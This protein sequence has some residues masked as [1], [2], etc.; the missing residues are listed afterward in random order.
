MTTTFEE[1]HLAL[2]ANMAL[3]APLPADVVVEPTALGGVPAEWVVVP[4]SG[5]GVVLFFHGGGYVIGSP[6]T[7][8][9]L[10]ARIARA[11]GARAVSVDYRLAPAHPFPAALD[12]AMAAYAA[13]VEQCPS[14]RVA[15]AGDS[16]GAGLALATLVRARDEGLPLPAAV[17]LLSPWVD[18]S[19]SAAPAPVEDLPREQLLGFAEAYLAGADPET[20]L[21]SPLF[22]DLAGLPPCLVHVGAAE[23]LLP[24]AE[25]LAERLAAAGV[26]V[27]LER[28]DRQPH[29]FQ[30][31]PTTTSTKRSVEQV[32]AFIAQRTH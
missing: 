18:L 13:L 30:L 5:D 31:L 11:A 8:R 22:A 27:V 19:L 12:D 21:A 7:H 26:E 28:F 3:V 32:G 6:A 15:V 2:E 4:E 25:R 29:C 14:T 10:V 24:D 20:P 17:V 9:E 1:Q 23:T 16:A